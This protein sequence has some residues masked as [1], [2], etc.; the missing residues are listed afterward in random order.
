MEVPETFQCSAVGGGFMVRS[1]EE[2]GTRVGGG[3]L[4]GTLLELECHINSDIIRLQASSRERCPW[5]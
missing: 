5:P 4:L 2:S 3:F 1:P